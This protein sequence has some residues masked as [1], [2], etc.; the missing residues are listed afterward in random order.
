M[1]VAYILQRYLPLFDTVYL[2][3]ASAWIVL[4]YRLTTLTPNFV[5]GSIPNITPET[6]L[7]QYTA[8]ISTLSSL[9]FLIPY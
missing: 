3:N 8:N 5:D 6:C 7:K 2:T 4:S 1:K 9:S